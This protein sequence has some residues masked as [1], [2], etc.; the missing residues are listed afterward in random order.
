MDHQGIIEEVDKRLSKYK[1]AFKVEKISLARKVDDI[2]KGIITIDG[3]LFSDF[4]GNCYAVGVIVD[5][6]II[7]KGD[8]GRGARYNSLKN[9][10]TLYKNNHPEDMCIAVILSEDGMINVIWD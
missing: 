5:G 7:V 9:Y 4:D 10:V 2:P 3:A 1:R 8:S 6:K